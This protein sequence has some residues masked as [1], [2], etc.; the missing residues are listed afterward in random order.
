MGRP[1]RVVVMGD[2]PAEH[3]EDRVANEFLARAV[4]ALDRVDHRDQGGV[5]APPD[6]LRIM[7]RDQSDVVDEV[8][9]ERGHDPAIPGR[10]R[11]G[12]I[13]WA[14][15]AAG[16]RTTRPDRLVGTEFA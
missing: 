15:V 6:L 9:E 8:R 10:P 1:K 11:G 4:V 16:A 14:T 2:R 7:L 3:G 13:R 12:R 5:D